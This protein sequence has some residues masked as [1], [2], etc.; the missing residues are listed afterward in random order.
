MWIPRYYD[1]LQILIGWVA[2]IGVQIRSGNV[3]SRSQAGC[4]RVDA[5]SWICD[6]ASPV[7]E[8]QPNG[9]IEVTVRE[10]QNQVRVT[11][12]ELE[13]RMKCEVPSRHPILAFLLEHAGRLMS[14]FQ[15]GRVGRTAYELHAEATCTKARHHSKC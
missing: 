15:V 2:E 9:T 11:K 14:R 12:S 1:L 5:H 6:G 3:D 13:E 10:I 8:H 7:E 4:S